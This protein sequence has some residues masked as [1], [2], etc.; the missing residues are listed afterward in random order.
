M[1]ELPLKLEGRDLA[2]K[3]TILSPLCSQMFRYNSSP[4]KPCYFFHLEYGLFTFTN[5]NVGYYQDDMLIAKEEIFGPVQS[6][7]KY[8]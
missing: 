7:L 5:R 3:V 4:C 2:P 8:K 6:I 1:A